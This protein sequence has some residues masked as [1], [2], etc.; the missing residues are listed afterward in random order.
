MTAGSTKIVDG[1]RTTR[2]EASTDSALPASSRV[3]ARRALVKCSGSKVVFST[4]TATSSMIV[5]L[6]IFAGAGGVKSSAS[7]APEIAQ[8]QQEVG[9]PLRHSPHEVAVPILPVRHQ[10]PHRQ[11]LGA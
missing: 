9:G 2:G 8:Q 5:S 4:R 3:I 6:S 1:E 7:A 11:P 10:D